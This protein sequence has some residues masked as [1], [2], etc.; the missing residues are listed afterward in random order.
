MCLGVVNL[1]KLAVN[2][3]KKGIYVGLILIATVIFE[4]Q[5]KSYF[6]D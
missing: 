5:N 2:C 1:R 4:L 6:K 3:E